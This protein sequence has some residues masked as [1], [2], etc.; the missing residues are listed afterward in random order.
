MMLICSTSAGQDGIHLQHD[1]PDPEI[2]RRSIYAMK[3]ILIMRRAGHH[4]LNRAID[5]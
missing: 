1:S 2:H 5:I 3:P 4:R